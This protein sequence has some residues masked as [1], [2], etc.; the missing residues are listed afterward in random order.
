MGATSPDSKLASAWA[1]LSMGPQVLVEAYYLWGFHELQFPLGH[2]YLL[3][4]AVI[5]RLQMG[6]CFTVAS[7]SCIRRVTFAMV[8]TMGCRGVSV[9]VP[10][11]PLL[12]PLQSYFSGV[13]S[14]LA[15]VV[16]QVLPLSSSDLWWVC[17]A[18]IWTWTCL[19]RELLLVSYR[20]FLYPSCYQ[21]LVT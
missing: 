4:C 13:F 2:T 11:A 1:P 3:W 16:Q 14:L 21:I 7:K 10:G 12:S 17:P 20:S 9:W 19:T 15:A 6:V 8:F 18:A 5:C